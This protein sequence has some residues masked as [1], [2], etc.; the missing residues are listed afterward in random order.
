MARD[1]SPSTGENSMSKRILTAALLTAS[2]A[3]G[4]AQAQTYQTY[5]NFTY[6][7]DGSMVQRLGNTTIITPPIPMEP[8]F[9][10]PQQTVIC[11]T[12]GNITSCN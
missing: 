5:G 10:P 2:I 4:S 6:G 3:I 11:Q 12:F 9:G 8:Q 1:A 7:S